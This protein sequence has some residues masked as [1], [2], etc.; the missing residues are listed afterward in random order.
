MGFI[1]TRTARAGTPVCNGAKTW[2][3]IQMFTL[4]EKIWVEFACCYVVARV[5]W[6][7]VILWALLLATTDVVF[8]TSI[9]LKFTQTHNLW[10][11][12]HEYDHRRSACNKNNNASWKTT[13][14]LLNES[15]Q[16]LMKALDRII[17][18]ILWFRDLQMQIIMESW[19]VSRYQKL[20]S[21]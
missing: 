13:F 14:P 15:N 9:N 3:Y 11:Q 18:L 5:L 7:G 20:I 12:A 2:K 19:P 21:E 8:S 4:T 16:R 17:F 6:C 1:S 10:T